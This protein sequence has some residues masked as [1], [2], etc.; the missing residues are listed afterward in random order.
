M[1]YPYGM[2][3]NPYAQF[4]SPSF[5]AGGPGSD[6]RDRGGID[7]MD[8]FPTASRTSVLAIFALVFSL[9]CIP[10]T[11]ALA[12]IFG[13]A[14]IMFISGSRGRLGGLGMAIAG[15]LIGLVTTVLWLFVIIGASQ[16]MSAF[17]GAFVAPTS[18][19]MKALESG[20]YAGA[21]QNFDSTLDTA[22]TDKQLGEFVAAYQAE[23]GSFQSIP[24]TISEFLGAYGQ[25]GNLMQNYRGQNEF[26]MPAQFDSGMMVLLAGMPQGR[27]AQPQPGGVMPRL[28]NL[29]V[30]VA[31]G[32]E[33]WLLDPRT[34]VPV[35]NSAAGSGPA[36]R[37][38]EGDAV[39][40][41]APEADE[42]GGNEAGGNEAGAD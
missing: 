21:R 9:L 26:P 42:I 28:N 32:K 35:D 19:M 23:V 6:P 1:R 34:L 2:T 15:V 25:V 14:A 7:G 40:A 16:F 4:G 11:G 41:P 36:P 29:G 17:S 31:P 27:A 24:G 18:N 8:R 33:V 39:D 12:I 30:L 37:T 38:T 10:P 5:G 22:V 3:Q 13:G 20:D